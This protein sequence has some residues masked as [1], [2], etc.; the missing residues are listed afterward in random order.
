[1][2]FDRV[3][4]SYDDRSQPRIGVIHAS[5][6]TW[7]VTFDGEQRVKLIVDAEKGSS[8]YVYEKPFYEG[9]P[10]PV[11]SVINI[12]GL[13]ITEPPGA[14]PAPV[15]A[16]A[17]DSLGLSEWY[18]AL[19]S[20]QLRLAMEGM[21]RR[22]FW[23]ENGVPRD[24]DD[25]ADDVLWLLRRDLRRNEEL[26]TALADPRIGLT[27]WLRGALNNLCLEAARAERRAH[28]LGVTNLEFETMHPSPDPG[29]EHDRRIDRESALA[30]LA[31]Q[32]RLAVELR[33]RR[34]SYAEVAHEMQ[35]SIDQARYAALT[36]LD[37]LQELL[38][39]RE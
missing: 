8:A 14:P 11:R 6:G 10:P 4:I 22:V 12:C 7:T 25:L 28:R 26:R 34:M 27:P 9:L 39:A 37:P 32:Q 31:P 16:A 2:I 18:N 35:L 21:I 5:S 30:K 36:G 20:K 33:L 1:M 23:L 13:V 15:R 38:R 17:A 3:T 19:V 24:L 29:P